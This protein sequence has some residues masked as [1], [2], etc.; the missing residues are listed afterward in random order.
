MNAERGELPLTQEEADR[1]SDERADADI[2]AGRIVP[3]ALVR[4]WLRGW[5]TPDEKPMPGSWL[6]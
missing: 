1:L 2:A 4:D 6:K 5:G 3:H